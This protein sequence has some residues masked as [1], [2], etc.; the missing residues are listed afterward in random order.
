MTFTRQPFSNFQTKGSERAATSGHLFGLSKSWALFLCFCLALGFSFLLPARAQAAFGLVNSGGIYTVD[1]GAGLV[2]KVDQANGDITS[3]K[4]SGVE[5]QSASANGSLQR[6]GGRGFAALQRAGNFCA[7]TRFER[8]GLGRTAPRF[9]RGGPCARR[10]SGRG[11]KSVVALR[12]GRRSG[13]GIGGCRNR[14]Y[15]HPLAVCRGSI[16][17]G[18]AGPSAPCLICRGNGLK[19]GRRFHLCPADESAGNLQQNRPAPV[20]DTPFCGPKSRHPRLRCG[21]PQL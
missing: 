12:V 1:T 6:P 16:M 17:G 14:R 18:C 3:L 2:F 4:F 19:R 15:E 20:E 10:R 21:S 5:Y 11:R 13:P 8:R 7:L 9:W